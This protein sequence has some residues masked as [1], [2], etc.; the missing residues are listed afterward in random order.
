M[1]CTCIRICFFSFASVKV[2]DLVIYSPPFSALACDLWVISISST[3]LKDQKDFNHIQNPWWSTIIQSMKILYSS[4]IFYNN[5]LVIIIMH[6][7]VSSD[8]TFLWVPN[9]IIIIISFYLGRLQPCYFCRH[10]A[11]K[12][13]IEFNKQWGMWKH[14]VIS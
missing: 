6:N 9:I 5:C 4:I 7:W 12:L 11:N 1:C 8:I 14:V 2:W 10:V 13:E 3:Q